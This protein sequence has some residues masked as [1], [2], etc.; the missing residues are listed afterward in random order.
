MDDKPTAFHFA[1]KDVIPGAMSGN[2]GSNVRLFGLHNSVKSAEIS[3]NTLNPNSGDG[4]YHFH[5]RAESFYLVL[6]GRVELR[7]ASGDRFLETGDAAYIP[8]RLNH[9]LAN[10]DAVPCRIIEVYVPAGRDFHVV[11]TTQGDA[12]ERPR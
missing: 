2:R 5:E 9:A 3:I 4:P 1:L 7:M 6:E 10:R 8:P 12:A 11:G